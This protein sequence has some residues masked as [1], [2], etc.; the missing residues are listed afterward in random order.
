[1]NAPEV[2]RLLRDKDVAEILNCSKA[3]VWRYAANGT[4][5]PPIRIGGMSR[6]RMSEAAAVIEQAISAAV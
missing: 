5:P 4:L 3:T 6:W 2:D 1:M